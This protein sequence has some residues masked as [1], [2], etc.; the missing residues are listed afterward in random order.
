MPLEGA[1]GEAEERHTGYAF[2]SWAEVE[3]LIIKLDE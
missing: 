1:A 3:D 2:R